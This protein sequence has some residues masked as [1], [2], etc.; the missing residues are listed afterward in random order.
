[1]TIILNNFKRLLGKRSSWVFLLLIPVLLNVFIVKVTT[2]QPKW[3]IGVLDQDQTQLTQQFM[4]NF[5]GDS[6][7]VKIDAGSD[8]QQGIVGSNYDVAVVFDKGYTEK[9]IAGEPARAQLYVQSGTNQTQSIKVRIDT[10]LSS[11]QSIGN[12]A[13]GDQKAFYSGMDAFVKNKFS[14]DYRNFSSAA[15]EDSSKTMTTLG[16]LAFSMLLMMTAGASLLLQDRVRGIYDRVTLSG[17]SCLS[18]FGQY[19]ASL[20]AITMIQLMAVMEMLPK[21]AG[22]SYGDHIQETA[23]VGLSA[24]F[25][26]FCVA[27]AMLVFRFVKNELMGS[28]INTLIDIPMVMLAGALWPR[29]LM[30]EALQRIGEF[31]PVYWYLD[32]AEAVM[33]TGAIGAALPAIGFL[34]GISAVLFGVTVAVRTERHR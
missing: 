25:G 32:G 30:P 19:I 24:A 26:L 20:F 15:A 2:Q 6:K 4:D 28:A 7:V 22:V 34:V 18:Y 1:M 12:A 11:V 14:S 10:Y 13:A 27:K 5:A 8:I 16:Y 3:S 17:T 21:M 9:I 33:S 23:I 31:L 29:E